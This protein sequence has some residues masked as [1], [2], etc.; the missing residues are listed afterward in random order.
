M[1][2]EEEM[3]EG[4]TEEECGVAVSG[5]PLSGKKASE[6]TASGGAVSGGRNCKWE[7]KIAPQNR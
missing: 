2:E 6:G 4:R 3:M 7:D 5:G 1:V